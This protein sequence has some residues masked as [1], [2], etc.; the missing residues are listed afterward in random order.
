MLPLAHI[1]PLSSPVF[2]FAH[3][4]RASILSSVASEE[5]PARGYY[6]ARLFATVEGK[7]VVRRGRKATDP[8]R[9]A[10]G[11]AG[12]PEANEIGPFAESRFQQSRQ[13]SVAA[14]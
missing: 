1:V 6:R 9:T 13:A 12:L 14:T 10:R 3:R 2:N 7:P 5:R 8:T 11:T 4:S